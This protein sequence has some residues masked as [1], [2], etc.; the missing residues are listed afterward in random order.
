M[1]RRK[2]R[3]FL[4]RLALIAGVPLAGLAVG[5]LGGGPESGFSASRAVASAPEAT[6][7]AVKWEELNL[8]QAALAAKAPPAPD[9]EQLFARQKVFE[10]PP[11]GVTGDL[12]R[13]LKF[14]RFAAE[15]RSPGQMISVVA[16]LAVRFRD[17][18]A[19]EAARSPAALMAAR[20]HLLAAFIAA[21][22]LA[23]VQQ[24]GFSDAAVSAA[25]TRLMESRVAGLEE[26]TVLKVSHGARIAGTARP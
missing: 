16:D 9:P 13:T 6:L 24:A 22:E 17:G 4:V 25:V 19:L 26:V 21:T 5:W 7:P 1:S 3:P 8:A 23:D 20:D 18:E 11:E 2:L 12:A 15:V 14:G 10:A